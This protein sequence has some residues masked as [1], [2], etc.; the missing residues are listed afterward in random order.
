[1]A[2]GASTHHFTSIYTEPPTAS[3][4]ERAA[5]TPLPGAYL[6]TGIAYHHRN[7]DHDFV[8]WDR[9]SDLASMC[10]FDEQVSMSSSLSSITNARPIPLPDPLRS[11][12]SGLPLHGSPVDWRHRTMAFDDMRGLPAI[13]GDVDDVMFP[14]QGESLNLETQVPLS[15][16]PINAH[17][18]TQPACD[19]RKFPDFEIDEH[20]RWSPSTVDRATSRGEFQYQAG[21]SI[22]TRSQQPWR[23]SVTPERHSEPSDTPEAATPSSVSP[24]ELYREP[25]VYAETDESSGED[26]DYPISDV[27]SI[28]GSPVPT[29]YLAG[30]PHA[31]QAPVD[32]CSANVTS[33]PAQDAPAFTTT[34]SRPSDDA[35][36][37]KR[38][39]EYLVKMRRAGWTYRRIRK[40]GKF[41]EVEATLRGRFR[42][43]TKPKEER[44]RKPEWLEN[45]VRNPSFRFRC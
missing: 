39:A 33:H 8:S 24:H 9:N 10:S 3:C 2:S 14:Q 43:L 12:C 30:Y 38:K 45:D 15:I 28:Q 41:K 11:E 13:T 34:P 25:T 21:M 7:L 44:V 37:R 26:F 32:T 36:E 31:H 27:S 18:L 29:G 19:L 22:P 42:E 17:E 40:E 1:M 16:A 20:G 23:Y 35:A 5:W 4:A 6:P